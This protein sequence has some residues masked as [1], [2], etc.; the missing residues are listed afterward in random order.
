[1]EKLVNDLRAL[2]GIQLTARQITAFKKYEEAEGYCHIAD[3]EELKE[4]EF[5]LNV[6]RYVDISITEDEIDIQNTIDDLKVILRA[7]ETEYARLFSEGALPWNGRS[8]RLRL[9]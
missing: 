2:V 9:T 7:F 3:I 8:P 5:N 1:M 6:P 4:N